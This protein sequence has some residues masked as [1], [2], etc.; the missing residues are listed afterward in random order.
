MYVIACAMGL[1]GSTNFC[2]VSSHVLIVA[3]TGTLFCWRRA[4]RIASVS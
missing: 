1:R 2:S 3:R 4:S